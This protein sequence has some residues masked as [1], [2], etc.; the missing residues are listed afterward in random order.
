[1]KR[2]SIRTGN[3]LFEHR[4]LRVI[5]TDVRQDD[6]SGDVLIHFTGEG[7]PIQICEFSYCEPDRYGAD[8]VKVV[9]SAI[10]EA[11]HLAAS[12]ETLTEWEI[13]AR[14]KRA[15]SVAC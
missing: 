5:V 6:G 4:D 12:L 15:R 9:L 10:T 7:E 11:C 3:R 14:V 2:T 1:M 13:D 8:Y